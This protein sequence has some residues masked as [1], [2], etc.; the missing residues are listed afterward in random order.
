MKRDIDSRALITVNC[1]GTLLRGTY[2]KSQERHSDGAVTNQAEAGRLGVLILNSLSLQRAATGDSAVYWADSLAELGYPC[3]RI[4][5]PGLGDSDGQTPTGFLDFI[6]RGG[7]APAVSSVMTELAATYSLSGLVVVGHCAGAVS[8]LYAAV[9]HTKCRGLVLMDPYFH[10]PK[11][12]RAKLRQGLS[13]W[14]SQNSFGGMISDVYDRLKLVLLFLCGNAPP[15]NAN[16]ALLN[17][18]K[19]VASEGL[20][21]LLLKA[22]SPKARGTEPRLGEFDYLSYVQKL[23]GSRGRVVL[24][25]IHDSDHSF[26]NRRGRSQVRSHIEGWL[27]TFFP[28]CQASQAES[29][30]SDRSDFMTENRHCAKPCKMPIGKL[31]NQNICRFGQK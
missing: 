15:K 5:L 24:R 2:H 6:N 31:E 8:A 16:A 3:F 11:V 29:R 13:E 10:L 22:P 1:S 21:I 9:G 20:P 18:W 26:A 14:A 4:D 19:Q 25:L 30:S 17:S 28:E 12:L 23:A 7:Y 27:N